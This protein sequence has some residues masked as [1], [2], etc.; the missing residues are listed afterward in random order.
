[1]QRLIQNTSFRLATNYYNIIIVVQVVP[2]L[3]A[4][5]CGLQLMGRG[6]GVGARGD[7]FYK[8]QTTETL[9]RSADLRRF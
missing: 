4:G 2:D 1:M 5:A 9:R 6:W 7:Y 3:I 8:H